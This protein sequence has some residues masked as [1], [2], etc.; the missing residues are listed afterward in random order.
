MKLR[1]VPVLLAAGL[2]LQACATVPYTN[3][4]QLSLV[5]EGDENEMGLEAYKDVK[6]KNKISTD[7]QINAMVQRV[8]KRIAAAADKPDW[9]WQFTVIDDPKTINAF[10]L[11]GGR[12]AV[13]TGILP[14][15]RD[16]NGL[17][18]VLGHETSHA[19]AHHGAERMSE[20]KIMGAVAEIASQSGLNDATLQTFNLAYGVG[21]GL[22]HSRK[23]ESEADHIGLIL[24]AKA[25]Y[26]PQTAVGFWERMA[27]EMQGKAPPAFLSDHPSDSQRIDKIKSELP[28]AL[29]YYKP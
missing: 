19:L 9:D 3:R 8:G 20:A 22:P 1:S 24:M 17:A 27:K 12:I 6:T 2:W 15:T 14:L 11:P 5:S 16:E 29:T 28:E 25:G 13:Y 10:C 4:R 23:Q 21:R 7:P 26:N 18:V